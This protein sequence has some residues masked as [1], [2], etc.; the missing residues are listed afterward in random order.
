MKLTGSLITAACAAAL[1]GCASTPPSELVDARLA[2]QHANAGPAVQMAPA[3][4]HKASEALARAEE[5]FS[6]D[7]DS[8]QTRDLAYVAQRTAEM[9]GVKASIAI[10][11]RNQAAS[12]AKLVS[13]QTDLLREQNQDLDRTRSELD[14]SRQS[15]QLAAKELQ[16]EKEARMESDAKAVAAH[17][18]LA[19]LASI[20]E[21]ARGTVITLSGSV[22]FRSNE[23]TLMPG[24][25]TRLDQVVAAFATTND[26][27][28]VVEGYADSQ[29]NDAYN[30]DL[31]Q[32]RAD[33][34]RSYLV[35]QGYP[36]DRVLAEGMGEQRPIADNATSEGR[37]NNR[38]VEIVLMNPGAKS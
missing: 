32:R 9:A 10:E 1:C 35:R 16:A 2:Y 12:D 28:V 22:L 18:A 25:D 5:S 14:A 19:K 8:Y 34:V 23:S 7:A 6:K 4:L 37:A 24:A 11:K 21:E 29:G 26:R 31:S 27:N 36:A 33:T 13:T 17:A 38:R 15:G 3:D 20:K 30:L